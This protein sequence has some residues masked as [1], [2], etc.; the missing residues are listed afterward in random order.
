MKEET[1][2]IEEKKEVAEELIKPEE[3]LK[4]EE[5]EVAVVVPKKA[6][7]KEGWK[8]KTE[9]GKKVKSGEIKN[10]DEILDSGLKI[11]ESE[12][13]DILLPNTE[14]VLLLIGQSKGKFG[15]G[16]RRIFKQTQ[17]KTR[18]GNKPR[19]E[20]IA[21]IGDSNGHIGVG[22]G[23][24]KETVPAREKAIRRAKLNMMKI[25]R[26]CGSWLC[27]CGT[28]HTIPFKIEGKCGSCIIKLMPAPKGKGLCIES[29]C[30]KIIKLVGIK[31][32][33]SK[34]KGQ[35]KTKSNLVFACVDA[36]RKLGET[37]IQQKHLKELGITE[38]S[39]SE[40][41]EKT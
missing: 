27:G 17:K 8:P 21:V 24:S 36:L 12:I 37:K 23:K 14:T 32:I 40:A 4:E 22:Y 26:G 39:A 6:F 16:Q 15:G 38:G 13:V 34:T 35:T 20:A 5:K 29:E 19:F 33:W 25:R 10:I 28:H 1:N 41:E 9:L 3:I 7:N 30:A 31:D 2:E 18:E 11:M